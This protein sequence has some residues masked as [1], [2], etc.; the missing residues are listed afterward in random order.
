MLSINVDGL[1]VPETFLDSWRNIV[2]LTTDFLQLS[3]AAIY[4]CRN[5]DQA[6]ELCRYVSQD[7]CAQMTSESVI[8]FVHIVMK[9]HQSLWFPDSGGQKS[10]EGNDNEGTTHL[11]SEPVSTVS[12]A[13]AFP[14]FW[15]TRQLFGVLVVVDDQHKTLTENE[16][17]LL[18]NYHHT[19]ESHLA[20]IYQQAEIHHLNQHVEQ[21]QNLDFK[22][23]TDFLCKEIDRRKVVEQQLRYHKHYDSGTGFLN[24]FSLDMKLRNLL[25]VNQ[26]EFGVIYIGFKNAYLLQSQFGYQAWDEVLKQYRKQIA[27]IDSQFRI[28]TGRPNSTDLVLIVESDQLIS[29]LE[30]ICHALAEQSQTEIQVQKHSFP[31]RSFAGV[32]TASE[33]QTS[34]ALVEDAFSAMLSCKESGDH[35]TYSS[36]LLAKSPLR[37]HQLENFLYNAVKNENMLLYFQP[38]VCPD[39]YQWQGAEALLRWQ[40]PVLGDISNETLIHLAEKNGLIFEIGSFVLHAAIRKA[41]QWRHDAPVFKIAVNISAKQLCDIRLVEQVKKYLKEFHLPARFLE[42]E[43]TES[44][45]ITDEVMAREVLE[46]LHALGITLSLD[47]FGTGYASFSYLKKYPFDCIKIDKSFIHSIE[48]NDKDRE[49]V[50]SIIQIAGKLDLQVIAEGIETP[51]QE[52]FAISEGCSFCQGFLYGR[53]MPSHEF[54]KKLIKQKQVLSGCHSPN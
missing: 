38:K 40:H 22:N 44:A 31:L 23:L 48:H 18:N 3:S 20:S 11:V 21:Y 52:Q 8:P 34:V 1:V 16:S 32:S 15:P 53:P 9:S 29:D 28:T 35:W 2:H 30:T 41:S 43:V 46:R 13:G 17:L 54:E 7:R 4:V 49:I 19:I 5:N 10:D 51:A 42:I 25:S 26:Q 14:L 6:E 24:R 47:D 33:G 36:E 37:I 12:M 27:L 39:T 50:R 45:L